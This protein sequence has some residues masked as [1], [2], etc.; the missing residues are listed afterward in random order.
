MQRKIASAFCILLSIVTGFVFLYSAYTKVFTLESF[1][2]FQFTITEYLH[3]PW[4]LSALFAGL[5]IGIEAALGALLVLN[6][7]G[8]NKWVLKG[9]IAM[10][11]AFSIYLIY[12][13]IKVG[14]DI[15]CGCFGDAIWMSPSASLI[16]NLL[17]AIAIIILLKFHRGLVF[18]RNYLL[19]W[20]IAAIFIA[21]PYIMYPLPDNEPEW[22]R[23][24]RH[25]V[26]LSS[27]YAPGKTDAPKVD[28][29]KGKHI[30]AFLSLSCPHCRVAAY[31]MHVMKMRN[32]SLPFH[33]VLAG[34]DKY[35]KDFFSETKAAN[36][37]YTRLDADTFT[38][39][40][41][42]SWP[43]IYLLKDSWI[44]AETNYVQMDQTQIENWVNSTK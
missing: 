23:K 2:T 18:K 13:W 11:V 26:D 21:I 19:I 17:L 10:L 32:P 28:L 30:V 7:Y 41:G 43:V 31:K 1:E 33:M 29:T 24:D 8:K 27:L 40:V 34:K 16:K 36:I 6:L 12:L 3:F 25:Q 9:A 37:P 14:N 42:F 35:W 39:L 15:N 5:M 44:E 38:G 20:A 22:I 4:V